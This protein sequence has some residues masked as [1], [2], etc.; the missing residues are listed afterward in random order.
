MTQPMTN[1]L[2]TV[3][4]LDTAHI[5]SRSRRGIRL[6][7]LWLVDLFWVAIVLSSDNLLDYFIILSTS[8]VG[9]TAILG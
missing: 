3:A 9:T 2:V 6:L 4:L 8:L 1:A 7:F 5:S